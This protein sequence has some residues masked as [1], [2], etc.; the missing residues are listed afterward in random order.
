MFLFD[1]GRPNAGCDPAGARRPH[2]GLCHPRPRRRDT[3]DLPLR[4]A[5]LQGLVLQPRRPPLAGDPETIAMYAVHAA[6]RGLSLSSLRVALA[7]I[8]AA[9]RLAG[10][11]LDLRHPRLVMLLEG[12]A[13]TKGS[14]P[15]KQAIVAGPEVLWM[16]ST[17]PD[18]R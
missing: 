1:L 9:H 16:L 2:R 5:G 17:T 4:L 6:D 10:I 13:R 12:I 14:R 3:A 8:Q 18:C 15:A 7:A 11:A